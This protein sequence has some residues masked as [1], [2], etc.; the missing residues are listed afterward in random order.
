MAKK[1]A[2]FLP[3]LSRVEWVAKTL[4]FVLNLSRDRNGNLLGNESFQVSIV[5]SSSDSALSKFSAANSSL[6][7]KPCFTACEI[8]R[9]NFVTSLLKKRAVL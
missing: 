8:Y 9:E 1:I 6:A 3:T 5:A 2:S 4:A 7:Q